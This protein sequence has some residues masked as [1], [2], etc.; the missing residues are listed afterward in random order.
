M[1]TTKNSHKR[2]LIK[3]ISWRI[4]ATLLTVGIVYAF[5]R[6]ITI[7]LGVGLVEVIAKILIYYIHEHFWDKISWGRIKHP[8]SDLQIRDKLKPEDMEIIRKK[9]R[10][11]GYLD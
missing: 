3:A 4:C 10:E 9:L 8:L 2:I 5:T 1:S 11:L 7:S 6:K